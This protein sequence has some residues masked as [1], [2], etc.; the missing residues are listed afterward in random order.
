[1]SLSFRHTLWGKIQSVVTPLL[2]Y[3]VSVIDRDC[4][5]DLLLE[6]EEHIKNLWLEI[7]SNKKM[8]SVPFV[9]GENKYVSFGCM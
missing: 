3:L 8:F 9:R 5:M 4:N 7:F 6:D 2:A 1:M